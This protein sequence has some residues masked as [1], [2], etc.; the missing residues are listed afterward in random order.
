MTL[1][2]TEAVHKLL[3][4]QEAITVPH[5]V[6]QDFHYREPNKQRGAPLCSLSVVLSP[7]CPCLHLQYHRGASSAHSHHNSCKNQEVIVSQQALGS[8]K[9]L[10]AEVAIKQLQLKASWHHKKHCW[11]HFLPQ[12]F[13]FQEGD[14]LWEAIHL[15]MPTKNLGI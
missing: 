12:G 5:K 6:H 4:W 9:S 15:T 7:T 11:L 3:N 2:Y 8:S 13:H 1:A 14:I 10:L